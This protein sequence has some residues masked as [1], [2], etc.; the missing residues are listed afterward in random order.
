MCL[1]GCGYGCVCVMCAYVSI[2]LHTYYMLGVLWY[3]LCVCHVGACEGGYCTVVAIL[4]REQ[5]PRR[6]RLALCPTET[7]P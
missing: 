3:R 7:P 2:Y 4:L 1:C 5:Q 6:V